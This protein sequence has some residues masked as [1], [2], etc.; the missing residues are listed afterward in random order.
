[1]AAKD[2][3]AAKPPKDPSLEAA[4]RALGEQVTRLHGELAALRRDAL[5]SPTDAPAAGPADCQRVAQLASG[6]ASPAKV[7][8]AQAL[9]ADGPQSAQQLGATAGLTTGSLYHHLRDLV[10][11][12]IAHTDSKGTYHLTPLGARIGQ[13]LFSLSHEQ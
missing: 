10:H 3:K 12:G 7:A 1:M 11:A 8:L 6:F 5:A 13:A 2:K 4:V 9:L